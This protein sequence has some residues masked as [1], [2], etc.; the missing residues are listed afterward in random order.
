LENSLVA[1]QLAVSQEGL[2][3]MELVQYRCDI[4][5][6]LWRMVCTEDISERSAVE[7][8]YTYRSKI[9]K[10][11]TGRNYMICIFATFRP[12]PHLISLE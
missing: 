11:G 8:V 5:S 12:T 3:C 7:D 10:Y 4:P 2:S 1:A 6:L 9:T